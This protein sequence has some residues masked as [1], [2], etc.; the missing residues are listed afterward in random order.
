MNPVEPGWTTVNEAYPSVSTRLPDCEKSWA[1]AG[2]A[3]VAAKSIIRAAVLKIG[4]IL[5]CYLFLPEAGY[6]LYPK[7]YSPPEELAR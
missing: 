7:I 3:A 1:V 2:T 5:I 6:F 4:G